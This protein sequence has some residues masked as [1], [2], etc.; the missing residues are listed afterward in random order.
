MATESLKE[1]ILRLKAERHAVIL[2]H[3]YQRPEIQDIA[4]FVGDSLALARQAQAAECDVIVFC[5]VHF[6]A[7]TACILNPTRTVLLPDMEAACSLE[8]SCPAEDLKRFLDENRE[9]NY[10]VVAYVNCSIGVKALADV[11]VTSG[12]SQRIIETAPADRPILFVPDKNLGAWTASKTGREMTL[13]DGACHVHRRFT[14]EQVQRAKE[15]HPQ[16]QVVCHPECGPGVRALADHVCSTEKMIG[17][18]RESACGSFIIVTETGILHR[19]RAL[20]PGKEFIPVSE[21]AASCAE[22]EY[23]KLNSLEKLR[24]CLR[25]MAPVVRI[26]EDLRRRAERPLLRMLELSK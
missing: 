17:Y 2:A 5:G 24:D 12:N 16:A 23:M 15:A 7:E 25:D 21:G 9:K 26:D 6:M 19:L 8:A 18:C 13:W 11:I 4:D 20:V 1:E 14:A 3:S 10:Y 22:C